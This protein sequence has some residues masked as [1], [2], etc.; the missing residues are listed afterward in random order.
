M[1]NK[2]FTL[3][4]ILI[5]ISIL[6]TLMIFSNQS[7]QNAIKAK[8]KIHDRLQTDSALRDALRVMSRD[9]GLAYH[10]RDIETEYKELVKKSSQTGQQPNPQQ[11]AGAVP[12]GGANPQQ[13]AQQQMVAMITAWAQKDPD[14]KDPTTHFIGSSEEVHFATMNSAQISEDLPQAD[15]IK[16]GYYLADCKNLD[17][18]GP[19]S[20][21]LVR[22]ADPL[23]EGDITKNGPATRLLEN[24]SEFKLRYIGKGKQDWVSDWNSKIGD[25]ATKDNFPEAVEITITTLTPEAKAKGKPGMT[26]SI[27]APIHFHN[28]ADKSQTAQGA[29]GGQPGAPGVPGAATIPGGNP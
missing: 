20:K 23:I 15:F 14:R 9:I 17:D 8:V 19:S 4:E 28:N 13:T 2:G 27:S 22:S 1:K 26:M 10:Y 11:P 25:A 21:C 18:S 12:T 6:S 29:Q 24:V 7:I 3:L 16:V 5:A